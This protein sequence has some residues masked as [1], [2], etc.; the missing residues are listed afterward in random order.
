MPQKCEGKSAIA[1][2]YLISIPISSV[3]FLLFPCYHLSQHLRNILTPEQ[4]PN[5][6]QS[7]I[8]SINT[9]I[10]DIENIDTR[11]TATSWTEREMV[12]MFASL[13]IS[14]TDQYQLCYVFGA[15]EFSGAKIGFS[16]GTLDRLKTWKL[17]QPRQLNIY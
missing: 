9:T 11:G 4:S 5:N 8:L 3:S 6:Y 10:S 14:V 1:R 16:V 17:H 2:S 12:C 15:I 7:S 13:C